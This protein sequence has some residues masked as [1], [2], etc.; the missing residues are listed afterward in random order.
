M[1][2]PLSL[3]SILLAVL[4]PGEVTHEKGEVMMVKKSVTMITLQPSYTYV[5]L[6]VDGGG[7]VQGICG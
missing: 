4:S 3:A 5:R 1:A 7:G 6:G 2:L